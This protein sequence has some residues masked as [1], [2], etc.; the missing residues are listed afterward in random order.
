MK[1]NLL[2]LWAK[3]SVFALALAGVVGLTLPSC[4]KEPKEEPYREPYEKELFFNKVYYDSIEPSV[5]KYFAKDKACTH[6]YMHVMDDN[7]F[8][9]YPPS[10]VRNF[11][12]ERINISSKIS[13]R[14]DFRF[15]VGSSAKED[16]IWFVQNGWT[17]N[18]RYWD[19]HQR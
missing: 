5:L 14:G 3:R 10:A 17:V 2:T 16:S 15:K 18:K 4:E 13:G 19:L 12:Q 1:R 6:I 9:D 11:L 7:N 8:T